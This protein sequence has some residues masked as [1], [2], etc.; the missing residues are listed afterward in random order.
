MFLK[1]ERPEFDD[2]KRRQNL[3][4]KEKILRFFLFLIFGK[5]LTD[6]KNLTKYVCMFFD[7]RTL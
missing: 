1:Q 2:F 5:Y 6:S 4:C 3:G 7:F